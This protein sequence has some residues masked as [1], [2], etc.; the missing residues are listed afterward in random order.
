MNIEDKLQAI[1][2]LIT[3][4]MIEEIVSCTNMYITT[5]QLSYDRERDANILTK[6][7]LMAFLGLLLVTVSSSR[8]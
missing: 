7:E 2:L 4:E 6:T 3:D 1:L 8:S 5:V